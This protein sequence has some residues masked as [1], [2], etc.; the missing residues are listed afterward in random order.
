[1]HE[2]NYQTHDLELTVVVFE[3]KIWRQYLYGIHVDVYIN[4]NSLQ[5]VFTK[6]DLNLRQMRWLKL[7]KDYVISVKYHLGKANAVVNAHSRMSMGSVSQLKNDG[8]KK[9]ENKVHRSARWEIKLSVAE[10]S[11]SWWKMA[12]NHHLL[13]MSSQ[14]KIL[15]PP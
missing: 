9:L 6:L 10:N 2:K 5:Y 14:R 15:I 13:R 11:V 3:L 12:L 7:F 1:M 4:H 8:K